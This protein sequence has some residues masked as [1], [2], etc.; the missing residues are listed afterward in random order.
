MPLQRLANV[1][2]ILFCGMVSLGLAQEKP[3][4]PGGWGSIEGQFVFDGPYTPELLFAQGDPKVKD[5]EI[6]ASVDLP[7]EALVVDPE[8]KG[9]ANIFVY[10]RNAPDRIH[11]DLMAIPAKAELTA[12]GCRFV[13]HC[14]ILRASQILNIK[15][16]D[17]AAHNAHFQALRNSVPGFIVQPNNPDGINHRFQLPEHLPMRVVCDIHNW[18]NGYWIV[19]DHPYASVT[20]KDGKFKIANL[21]AGEHSFCVWQERCGYVNREYKVKVAEGKTTTLEVEN[22]P[23]AKFAKK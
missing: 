16:T 8:T 5:S 19:L 17:D 23:A 12:K 20:D 15:Y 9:I 7:D 4:A 22:V 10:L 6:C 2:V 3:A 18:M 11:P 21:P 13:P 14:G 1:I